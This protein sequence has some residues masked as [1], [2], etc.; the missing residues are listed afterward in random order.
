M[1]Y[2]KIIERGLELGITEIELYIQTNHGTTMRVFEGELESYQQKEYFGMAVR[3]LYQGK[4]GYVY[5]EKLT[6]TDEVLNELIT[7]ANSLTTTDLEI[8]YEGSAQYQ[9]LE[10]Q[11]ADFDQYTNLEKIEILQK[12]EKDIL[13][14]DDRIK[15]V[16]YCQYQDN[17]SN[18]KI[19]NSKGLSLERNF[20]YLFVFAG[21]VAV[22]DGENAVGYAGEAGYKLKEL[23]YDEMVKEIIADATGTLKAGSV[24]SG[25]YPVVLKRS[26][27]TDILSAF[28]SIFSGE[29]AKKK[30]TILKDRLNDLVFG[31]NIT[32]YD[33]PFA[34]QAVVKVPFD[35]EGVPC[36]TKAIVENGVFKTFLHNLATAD[37]FKTTSTGNGFKPSIASSVRVTPTN[38]YLQPGSHEVDEMIASLDLGIYVTDV[39]GL[40]SGLNPISGD[41][42]VQATGYLVENGKVVRPITLFV[43]SGNFYEMMNNV[44]MIGNDLKE[45]FL[46]FASPSLK[47]KSLKISGK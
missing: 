26:V 38:L 25:T 28:Q 18:T 34:D 36:Y 2:Q 29:S 20:S 33:D 37:F 27:A 22:E 9:P 1:I 41:F 10:E 6:N 8:I 39:A 19:I 47:I 21:A 17:R 30:L 3:G 14:A 7:N 45:N 46:S 12:L 43:V 5:T 40:H 44:E 31:D 4:M 35:D 42:N 16:S 15:K 32:I 11:L 23:P 24:Q 13:K